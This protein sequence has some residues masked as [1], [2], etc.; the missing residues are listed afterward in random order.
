[1]LKILYIR[2]FTLI[3]EL[4]TSFYDG[5]SVITG[6]TGAG[7]SIILGAL[8][9]LLGNRADTKLIKQGEQKC[10]I[11]AH[12]NLSRYPLNDFFDENDIEFDSEDTILRRELNVNGKSR[13]FINDTP[14][15]L[16]TLKELGDMLVDIHS[17]HQ[18][19][20]LNQENFQL[21]VVDTIAQNQN[22]RTAFASLYDSFQHAKGLLS[23]LESTLFRNRKDEDYMRF[24]LNELTEANLHE[25]EQE[26]L[27]EQSRT[28]SHAE[29]IKQ[30][31]YNIDSLLHNEQNGV[32]EQLRNVTNSAEELQRLYPAFNE[33]CERTNSAYIELKDIADEISSKGDAFDFDPRQLEQINSR[34]DLIY[35]LE[36]K[37]HVDSI[38]ELISIQKQ[39]EENVSKLD[40]GEEELAELQRKVDELYAKAEAQGTVL[41][42]TRAKAAKVIEKEVLTKLALLG[43]PNA[44]FTIE[45]TQKAIGKDGF[46]KVNFLFSANKGTALSPISQVASGGE[47]ARLMLALKAM[48]SGQV[49]LPT[50]I[51]DEIDTGV[52][53]RIAEQMANIMEEMGNNN[54]QVISITHLPQI[55]AKG[56]H[57]YKVTKSETSD[58]TKS[59]LTQ[60]TD[61]Q[62]IT[63]IAQMLSGSNITE[64]AISNAKELLNS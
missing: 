51:F 58:G 54:R 37:H 17:Q 36:K 27:E 25:G 45:I 50:I 64:A 10:V 49:K 4:S 35:S 57:H 62:R 61:E 46:D 34:L 9:M 1:M 30:L 26:E 11:E 43:I 8:G 19:L 56:K 42:K 55:A 15:P 32:I 7:K 13:A 60:L 5:F 21:N 18:N 6:E 40:N 33:L 31:I 63:E 3:D 39:L 47:I 53:G 2:N 20:L 12:F 48:I 29:D 52:S 14:V 22:E 38:G 16:N 41:S 59:E 28:M 44:R 23:E 24:Q